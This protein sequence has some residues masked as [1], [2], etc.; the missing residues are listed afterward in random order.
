[1]SGSLANKVGGLHPEPN[2][3]ETPTH[4]FSFGLFQ[5]SFSAEQ[6]RVSGSELCVFTVSTLARDSIS[7]MS[8]MASS[9]LSK[10]LET[11]TSI[12][13]TLCYC[14]TPWSISRNV[15]D[16]KTLLIF[17]RTTDS[18]LRFLSRQCK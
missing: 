17:L 14:L 8:I 7:S 15:P 5:Y 4:M 18:R 9:F 16:K 1:M 10:E 13:S 6:L 2:E 12:E 3:N 11:R